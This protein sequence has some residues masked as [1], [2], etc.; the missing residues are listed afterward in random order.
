MPAEW[1]N[2]PVL[3]LAMKLPLV[4]TAILS[5]IFSVLIFLSLVKGGVLI[6]DLLSMLLPYWIV[7]GLLL[8]FVI[9]FLSV[10]PASAYDHIFLRLSA[11][12]LIIVLLFLVF[13]VVSFS[14][15][16]EVSAGAA[17]RDSSLSVAFLN[18]LYSNTNYT[19]INEKLSEVE[20]DLLGFSEITKA[21]QD[22]IGFLNRFPYKLSKKSRDGA[23][24]MF[25]SKYP[26]RID[27]NL[28]LPHV[29]PVKVEMD[30]GE[31]S[32]FVIHPKPP[33]NSAWM[34]ARN[35]ELDSLASYIN[36]LEDKDKVLVLGD[37][38]LST[39]SPVYK[40]FSG[41]LSQLKDSAKGKGFVFTWHGSLIRTQIDHL[42]VPGNSLVE[43]F[44]SE[45][46]EGSDHNLIWSLL[47]I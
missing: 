26:A 4:T 16:S 47:K 37:F 43:D 15:F 25:Y 31:Y 27:N 13:Q 5:I 28:S 29:L 23:Q 1:G 44:Q 12:P 38:N 35:E 41:K 11:V 17:D 6:L 39:W 20:P 30:G 46:V 3:L 10:V 33:I 9:I 21:D 42:F 34:K 2:I 22:G 14:T 36:S 7:V 24:I 19:A 32:V 45:K 40:N 18:K 8:F